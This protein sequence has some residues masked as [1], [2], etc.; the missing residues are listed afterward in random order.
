MDVERD[1]R[2]KQVAVGVSILV[3]LTVLVVGLLLTWRLV[4]GLVGETLGTIMGI[5]TTPFF[6]EASFSILGL[7]TVI[8]IN[9]W[10][11]LKEGDDF[12]SLDVASDSE[13]DPR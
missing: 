6:M 11:Q 10:R 9:H 8:T 1:E 4:P 12:V 13:Q 2:V 3:L 7:V 5:V